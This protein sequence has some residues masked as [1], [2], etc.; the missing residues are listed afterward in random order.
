MIILSLKAW[1]IEF[2]HQNYRTSPTGLS[3]SSS[4]TTFFFKF[5]RRHY[6]PASEFK[7]GLKPLLQQGL[8]EPEFYGDLVYKNLRRADFSDQCRKNIIRYKRSGYNID[9]MRPSACLVVNSI[10]VNNIACLF[11][12]TPAGRA[13]DSMMDPT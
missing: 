13:P 2:I 5:Y 12:C 4:S 7:V 8:S 11:N 10:T 1:W 3:V 6:E 9:A